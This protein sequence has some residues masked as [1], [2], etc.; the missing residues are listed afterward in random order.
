MAKDFIFR[1]KTFEQIQKLSRK[2]FLGLIPSRARRTVMRGFN[3]DQKKLLEKI[4][5][6]DKNIK[7]HSRDM[8]VLP[9]M[10]GHVIK[11]YNGKEFVNITIV[12]EMLGHFLGEF[13]MTRKKGEHSAPGV[14]A[15]RS[16]AAIS[17][18]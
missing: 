1:G 15:T 4:K 2:E 17:V 8:V 5:N 6:N 13:A 11:V 16:S 7:T 12:E 14:G 18:R 3:H 10:V 9:E